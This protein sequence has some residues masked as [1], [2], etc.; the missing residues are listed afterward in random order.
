ME[1]LQAKHK[2]EL[3][4]F[5]SDKRIA[6]KKIK[7]TA[8]KGKKGKEVL[9][10]AEAEWE[11]KFLALEE[12]QKNEME[13]LIQSLGSAEVGVETVANHE[14]N[15]DGAG[16]ED[17]NVQNL[18]QHHDDN[19]DDG[20]DE[21]AARQ[22]K[23]EKKLRKKK[24][25]L[26]KQKEKEEQIAKEMAE[27][28][29]LRQL[30]MDA[31]MELHLNQ[32]D[33]DIEEVAADG[34][35]LYRAIARQ[36]E[37]LN[38]FKNEYDYIQIRHMCA[39]ELDKNRH[40]YEPFADFSEMRVASFDEYIEKVRNS[41]EWGGHLELRALAHKLKRTIVIY[42]TEGGPLEIVGV[43]EQGPLDGGVYNNKQDNDD[44]DDNHDDD[45]DKD[46]VIRLSFHRQYYALGEHYNSVISRQ[47]QALQ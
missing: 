15:P 33:L 13:C 7:G 36:L 20:N 28:P 2:K 11:S 19:N 27:A 18:Q 17:S 24:N 43:Q 38:G 1:D 8:G 10:E 31:I 46:R 4:T 29:N 32:Y 26:A 12:R 47:V 37:Y 16:Q 39:Q 9:A 30:E 6:L 40:E 44:D 42:S 25:A 3:K 34:N 5:E 23:L 14:N 41:N 22:K 21:A 35:C 45:D